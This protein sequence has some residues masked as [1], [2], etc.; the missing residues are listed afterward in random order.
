MLTA[1][2]EFGRTQRGNNNAYAQDN[3]ITWLDWSG[4]DRQIEDHAAALSAM[5]RGVAALR[6]V[7]FLTGEAQAGVRDVEWLDKTGQPLDEKGWNDPERRRLSMVLGDGLSGRFAAVF[8][9]SVAPAE[10][11]LP[12]RAGFRWSPVVGL[13]AAVQDAAV[14]VP[15]RSVVFVAEHGAR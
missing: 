2:D 5:R 1:G 4:R 7:G 14:L 11:A 9:G 15:G 3:A 12:K 8:N 10:F 13:P 6:D